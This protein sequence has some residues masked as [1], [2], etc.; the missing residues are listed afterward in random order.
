[1]RN[2]AIRLAKGIL[3][4]GLFAVITLFALIYVVVSFNQEPI[5][6]M[7]LAISIQV[8]LASTLVTVW[9]TGF[10]GRWAMTLFFVSAPIV[11]TVDFAINPLFPPGPLF[12]LHFV[13][14]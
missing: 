5:D 11:V 9:A 12:L 2:E 7:G 6:L 10:W 13:M 1:M 14:G 8:L 3:V 4:G